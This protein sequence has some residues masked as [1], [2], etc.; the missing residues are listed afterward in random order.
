MKYQVG[1][2]VKYDSGDWWFYGT[3]TAVIENAICP[4]YRVSVDRMVK[5]NCKF[6]ITQFEFELEADNE[7][8]KYKDY[9]KWEN[10]EIEFFDRF[11]NVR[12]NEL[13]SQVM[14]PEPEKKPVSI[15][16]PVPIPVSVSVPEPILVPEPIPVPV[17]VPE[18]ESEPVSIPVFVP[19]PEI[20]PASGKK[21][22]KKR[23][24]KQKQEPIDIQQVPIDIPQVPIAETPKPKRSDAWERHFELYQKGEKNNSI[25][26]WIAENRRQYRTGKLNEYRFE[27]L[28]GINFQF[29]VK[30]KQAKP[31]KPEKVN[32]G[33][34]W[35]RQYELWKKGERVS[36]QSWRQRSIKHYVD[37][38]L[39]KDKIEKLK[40]V[41]IL[42]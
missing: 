37:G 12:N 40:E 13:F 36:L 31:P 25:Y 19:E 35:D 21:Q 23:E 28:M 14:K 9:G 6:S 42:K 30:R 27:K 3:V 29:D 5:K 7:I 24:L 22:R 34:N 38:K 4:C 16:E 17:Y 32:L 33:D 20:I 39:S 15:P 1:N 11:H 10:A 26:N 41:G 18:P 2:K 8:E